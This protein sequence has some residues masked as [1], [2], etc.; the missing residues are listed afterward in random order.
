M[1]DGEAMDAGDVNGD[2]YND[3][4]LN[5][6]YTKSFCLVLG[7]PNISNNNPV[8]FEGNGD[9]ADGYPQKVVNIGS[10][11]NLKTTDFVAISSA[12][13]KD[14]WG[15]AELYI[16]QPVKTV[17]SI[18]DHGSLP[19]YTKLLNNYPNPFNPSTVI[20][21]EL[22]SKSQVSLKVYDI[23]GNEIAS[24]IKEQQTVGKHEV[25]FDAAKYHLASGVYF[26]ELCANAIIIQKKML[27]VQ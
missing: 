8:A 12:H 4:V 1:I 27:Y 23:L 10:Y 24:L 7:G 6:A 17:T 15:T 26:Y 11:N 25:M 14:N 22:E 13:Q 5:F 16:G 20:S 3:F 2:G 19:A 21:Y 18:K 9:A